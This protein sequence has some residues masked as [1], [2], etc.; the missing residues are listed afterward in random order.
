[1][2]SAKR[3]MPVGACFVAAAVL[4]SFAGLA[5]NVFADQTSPKETIIEQV[6]NF[7]KGKNVK[8]SEHKLREMAATV[9][10]ESEAYNL[11]YRLVLAIIK[12][13]SNFKNDAVSVKGARGLLQIKPSLAKYIAKDA[14]G[15]Y[16]GV[17]SLHDSDNNIRIG[18]YHLSSLLDDFKTVSAALYAYNAGSTRAKKKLFGNNEPKTPFTNHVLR[19]YRKNI[20]VLP[21]SESE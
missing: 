13:E 8:L 4:A 21:E 12:V 10:R 15:H 7:L 1:M 6:V 17:H 11:D 14:G 3:L 19:E 5:V 20:E 9:Y 18:V 16:D 2:L